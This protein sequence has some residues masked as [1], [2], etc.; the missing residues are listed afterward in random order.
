MIVD[1]IDELFDRMR[2]SSDWHCMRYEIPAHIT[3]FLRRFSPSTSMRM[4]QNTAVIC[5]V[6]IH[7][8]QVTGE[9]TAYRTCPEATPEPIDWRALDTV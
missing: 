8:D 9:V 5:T 2:V 7:Y 1:E 6:E 4:V 3:W